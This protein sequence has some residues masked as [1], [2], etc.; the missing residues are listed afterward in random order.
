MA[1]NSAHWE[2][3]YRNTGPDE[4]SWTQ[5]EPRPSWQLISDLQL[6]KDAGVIDVGGGDS[7]LVDR[8]LSEGFVNL[9]VL[10]ISP[11]ALERAKARLGDK[12]PLVR[13]IV[14][15]MRTFQPDRTYDVWHDRA[16]FHFLTDKED[17]DAYV[18]LATMATARYMVIGVFSQKGPRHCSGLG[19]STYSE[20]GLKNVFAA[21]FEKIRCIS[22]DHKTPWGSVQNF[23]FCSFARK[24]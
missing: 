17:I 12:A 22:D 18:K 8:L 5:E 10:D 20:E 6:P 11:A 1:D 15:D 14:A 23:V 19:V 13:W 9:A 3:I 21:G 4:V 16:A 2:N 7:K 24:A